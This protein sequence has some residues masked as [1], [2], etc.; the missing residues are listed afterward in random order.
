MG[1]SPHHS[2]VHLLDGQV[3]RDGAAPGIR[4]W[5]YA[6]PRWMAGRDDRVGSGAI[7]LRG[8]GFVM[9]AAASIFEGYRWL[10][11]IPADHDW[12]SR[13]MFSPAGAAVFA[14]LALAGVVVLTGRTAILRR[15]STAVAL[16]GA[17]VAVLTATLLLM[18]SDGAVT[19]SV[20]GA[21]DLMMAVAAVAALV[22]GERRSR[23]R[24][25]R[26]PVASAPSPVSSTSGTG[27]PGPAAR[28]GSGHRAAEGRAH[29]IP[30]T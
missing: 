22:S 2:S 11:A 30:V 12:T 18:V 27:A 25:P 5:W 13:L 26:G 9:L 10:G 1:R 19:R 29:S 14:N 23:S 15:L 28:T 3:N 16:P 4:S 24:S 7:D 20:L 17:S 21:A 8:P 6:G